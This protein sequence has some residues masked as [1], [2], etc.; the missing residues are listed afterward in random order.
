MDGLFVK[1]N[2]EVIDTIEKAGQ[3]SSNIYVQAVAVLIS[4]AVTLYVLW[5]GY[6]TLGGKMAKK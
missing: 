2:A 5:M 3:A 1:F 4:G 6:Q